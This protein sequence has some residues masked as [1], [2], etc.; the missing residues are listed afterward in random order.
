[1]RDTGNE[2][3]DLKNTRWNDR[4]RLEW[5]VYQSQESG[6]VLSVGM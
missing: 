6:A 2:G 1:M 4:K 3:F 5:S